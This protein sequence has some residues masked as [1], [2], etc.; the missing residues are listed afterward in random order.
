[1]KIC[2]EKGGGLLRALGV[3]LVKDIILEKQ[4]GRQ[5][6]EINETLQI[7]LCRDNVSG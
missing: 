4:R 2:E 5:N 7:R 3:S 6:N 1:M